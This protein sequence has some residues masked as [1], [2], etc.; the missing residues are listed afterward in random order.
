[1]SDR[2]SPNAGMLA[3]SK[4]GHDKDTVYAVLQED[5]D[6]YYL[7]DGRLRPLANPKKK[8][9]KHVQLIIHP[10]DEIKQQLLSAC[11]DAQIRKLLKQYRNGSE[12]SITGKKSRE[13]V[14]TIGGLHVEE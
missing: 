4:A 10:G 8:K 12:A 7:T 11:D 5:G 2:N 9:K 3:R 1:M 13:A 6:Y 14:K